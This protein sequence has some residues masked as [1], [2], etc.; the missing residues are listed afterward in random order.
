MNKQIYLINLILI[1]VTNGITSQ[2]K[3]KVKHL[4]PNQ[5]HKMVVCKKPLAIFPKT[6]KTKLNSFNK[7]NKNAKSNLENICIKEEL[8]DELDEMN[9]DQINL[10]RDTELLKTI[11]MTENDIVNK[12]KDEEQEV[13]DI[14]KNNELPIIKDK[15]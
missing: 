4:K 8:L 13:V 12:I 2:S 15:L 6:K 5:I 10:L 14:Y 11:S 7:I 1:S 9:E 3:V